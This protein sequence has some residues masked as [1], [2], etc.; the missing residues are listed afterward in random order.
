LQR[1]GEVRVTIDQAREDRFAAPVV[2]VG[3]RIAPQDLLA[4]PDRGN[5]V[6]HHRDRGIILDGVGVD[7]RC[8]AEDDRPS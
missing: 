5:R 1:S 4:R 2:D 7:D 3:V 8:I 6:A